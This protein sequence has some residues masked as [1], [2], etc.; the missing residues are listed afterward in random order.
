MPFCGVARAAV[1]DRDAVVGWVYGGTVQVVVGHD[2]AQLVVAEVARRL[3]HD[4]APCAVLVDG[5]PKVE[6]DVAH[7]L[8]ARDGWERGHVELWLVVEA[9]CIGEQGSSIGA[10]CGFGQANVRREARGVERRRYLA[11]ILVQGMCC[12][13]NVPYFIAARHRGDV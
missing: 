5:R 13:E 7:G 2:A 11:Q 8:G 4:Q 10:R 12:F 9:I 1:H 3:G 6:L